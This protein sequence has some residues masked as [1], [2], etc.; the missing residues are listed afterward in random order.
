[1]IGRDYFA[2]DASLNGLPRVISSIGNPI[3]LS[4]YLLLNFPFILYL[5]K[6]EKRKLLLNFIA[7]IHIICIFMTLSR[8]SIVILFVAT[9]YFLLKTGKVRS[10]IKGSLFVLIIGSFFALIFYSNGFLQSL[11]DR[12]FFNSGDV[13]YGIRTQAYG[14]A[15]DVLFNTNPFLGIGQLSVGDYLTN[16]LGFANGTLEN[17]FLTV[18]VGMGFIG[19]L[20]FLGILLAI[21][22]TFSKLENT[23][24]Y[25]GYCLLFIFISLSCFTSLLPYDVLWGVFWFYAGLLFL[26]NNKNK[27]KQ[28]QLN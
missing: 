14:I 9:F 8:S 12:L 3:I 6:I 27:S 17:V 28:R 26:E 20:I 7:T 18:L 23:L 1:M 13:S 2:Y 25:T 11:Q 21:L 10:L 19:L 15:F 5:Q 16:S 22:I 24:K 4:G